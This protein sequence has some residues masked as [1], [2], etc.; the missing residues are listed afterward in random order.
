MNIS[1]VIPNYNGED[2]LE[3]NLPKVLSEIENYKGGKIEVVVVDDASVDESVSILKDFEKKYKEFKVYVKKK[4]EGFSSTVNLGVGHAGG[5]IVVLLNTDVYPEKG[6]LDPLVSN[7]KDKDVFAVGCMDKSIEGS[8]I[9]LRGRGIG[10][11][12]RG[13][14]VH[15]RG[16]VNKK[17][18]LWASGGSAA[19]SREIWKKLGGLNEAY[20]PFYWEDIDL[21][22]RAQKSGYRIIFEPESIVFHEHAKGAIKKAYSSSRIKTIAYRN[23]FIFVWSNVTDFK[24]RVAHI[25][26][27]PY[28]FA[29]ALLRLD[30]AFFIAF[31]KA[32]FLL[33][34]VIEFNSESKKLF[35]RKDREVV[36]MIEE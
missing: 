13:F 30:I 31:M 26:F 8:N 2:V 29:K 15:K 23:Q 27:L 21:S 33:P 12:K 20:N 7:F 9:V 19:F 24:L 10:S 25:M 11:W 32:L 22:Y 6:F 5:E 14:L 1:I 36:G 35:T 17:D 28:H 18:T 3:K 34:K 4:N 16:E